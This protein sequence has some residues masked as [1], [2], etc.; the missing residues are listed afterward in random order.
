MQRIDLWKL[1]KLACGVVTLS[2]N[3]GLDSLSLNLLLL[4]SKLFLDLQKRYLEQAVEPSLI[5]LR[6]GPLD[7]YV[8]FL[9]FL[10]RLHLEF[11]HHEVLLLFKVVLHFRVFKDT[12]HSWL[13]FPVIEQRLVLLDLTLINTWAGG[14]NDEELA[15]VIFLF[16]GP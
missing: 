7:D 16:Q 8:N 5:K 13:F 15:L 6:H 9:L 4:L 10:S 11:A 14:D 1:S 12:F 3:C 2:L